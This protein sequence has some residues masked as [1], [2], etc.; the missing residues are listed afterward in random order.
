MTPREL[1]HLLRMSGILWHELGGKP[2]DWDSLASTLMECTPK[3]KPYA[4]DFF[5]GLDLSYDL[6]QKVW[7]F[8]KEV[9][10][11][12]D[13]PSSARRVQ[14][15]LECLADDADRGREASD[16]DRDG[17]APTDDRAGPESGLG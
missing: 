5:Q 3:T 8:L 2:N 17:P 1:L 14:T 4:M 6:A 9:R 13:E 11:D 12:N 16:G 10:K 15:L 7:T